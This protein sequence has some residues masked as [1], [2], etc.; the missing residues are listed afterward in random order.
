MINFK[1]APKVA[2]GPRESDDASLTYFKFPRTNIAQNSNKY[3]RSSVV[4]AFQS[5]IL[6][7][8]FKLKPDHL[9]SG[10]QSIIIHPIVTTSI[11]VYLFKFLSL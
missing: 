1:R 11:V 6:G 10:A 8:Y 3:P 4:K 2:L 9:S 5:V 7:S